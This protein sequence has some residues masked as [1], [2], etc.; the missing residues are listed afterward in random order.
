[1]GKGG[2]IFIRKWRNRKLGGEGG[3]GMGILELRDLGFG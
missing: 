2:M 3:G 1:M